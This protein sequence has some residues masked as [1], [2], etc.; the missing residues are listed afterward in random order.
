VKNHRQGV[1]TLT[2][3]FHCTSW[4]SATHLTN[5]FQQMADVVWKFLKI[6]WTLN[7]EYQP[8]EKFVGA[9]DTGL[10]TVASLKQNS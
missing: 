8:K 1:L 4:F 10:W 7:A 3:T 6:D 2:I 9:S 5:Y